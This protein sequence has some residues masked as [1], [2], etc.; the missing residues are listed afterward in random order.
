MCGESEL[1]PWGRSTALTHQ[2][3]GDRRADSP[4]DAAISPTDKKFAHEKAGEIQSETLIVT[5]RS[6]VLLAKTCLCSLHDDITAHSESCA[7]TIG[8]C[9]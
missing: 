1:I 6:H 4:F 9:H 2:I 3:S 7:I 5:N 8:L